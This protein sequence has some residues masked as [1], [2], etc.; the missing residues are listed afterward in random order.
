MT[1]QEWAAPPSFEPDGQQET[2]GAELGGLLGA[3]G[4]PFGH[5][6]AHLPDLEAYVRSVAT[7]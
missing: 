2:L 5:A 1:E 4:R 3:P 6:F 7:R